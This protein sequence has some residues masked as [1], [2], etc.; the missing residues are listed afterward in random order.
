M[1][2]HT[3]GGYVLLLILIIALLWVGGFVQCS[4]ELDLNM[5]GLLDTIWEY[6]S[7]VRIFT[8]KRGCKWLGV[9]VCGCVWVRAC[10]CVCVCVCVYVC[11][12]LL[13]LPPL[14]VSG[15]IYFLSLLE[16][17]IPVDRLATSG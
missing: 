16:V 17:C 5:D 1:E 12:S 7:L 4:C 10:A 14:L 8:K 3:L 2:L 6:L 15:F 11:A 13:Y 9:W